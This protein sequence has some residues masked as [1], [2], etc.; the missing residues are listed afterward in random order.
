L[1]I[2]FQQIKFRLLQKKAVDYDRKVFGASKHNYTN[3]P[4]PKTEIQKFEQKY[5]INLPNN[6]KQFLIEIGYGAGPNYGL[7]SLEEIEAELMSLKEIE[8]EENIKLSPSN[9]FPFTE[10]DIINLNTRI[11]NGESDANSSLPY[12][13]SYY[14]LDGCIPIS[15]QGC[16]YWDCLVVTGELKGTIWNV[17]CSVGYTGYWSP[18]N[19]MIDT[20]TD[21]ITLKSVIFQEWYLQWLDEIDFSNRLFSSTFDNLWNFFEKIFRK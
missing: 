17:A 19:K 15:H 20:D 13:E 16:T 10:T 11:K 8:D 6:Y 5:N 3:Y 2:D 18:T 1:D 4:V 12:L 7:Y 21:L 9:P 14:P